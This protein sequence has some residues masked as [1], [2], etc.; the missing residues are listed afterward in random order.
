VGAATGGRLG[1]L[2]CE[3]SRIGDSGPSDGAGLSPTHTGGPC[4]TIR[5]ASRARKIA[6]MASLPD[7]PRV[8]ADFNGLVT[9]QPIRVLLET[10]GTLEDLE[11]VSEVV[12]P[13]ADRQV[14]A[15]C[16]IRLGAEV[17][18]CA[19]AR[20]PKRP[21]AEGRLKRSLNLSD[22]SVA[23]DRVESATP[24]AEAGAPCPRGLPTPRA[25]ALS[26]PRSC[27]ARP[28]AGRSGASSTSAIGASP[29]AAGLRRLRATRVL[30]RRRARDLP[31]RAVHV[32]PGAFPS[33][34]TAAVAVSGGSTD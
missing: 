18:T 26:S 24:Q 28:A 12:P 21:S 3:R 1:H 25:A 15:D 11:A 8:Y 34:S 7:L 22:A 4:S 16:S 13:A 32:D 30:R 10:P 27:T 17:S 33:A 9:A 6:H 29:S 31:A 23:V 5:C 20:R 14:P 2:L 19:P